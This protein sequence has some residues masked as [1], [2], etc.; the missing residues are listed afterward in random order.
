VFEGLFGKGHSVFV[1][2]PKLNL[3]DTGTRIKSVDKT[4]IVPLNPLVWVEFALGIYALVSG[5]ILAP[6][7]GWGIVPWMLIYMLGF[8]YIGGMSVAQNRESTRQRLKKLS[9]E[10]SL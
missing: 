7:I 3:N 8:F 10:K 2:T 5:I 9:P 4:Y 6:I 1:R